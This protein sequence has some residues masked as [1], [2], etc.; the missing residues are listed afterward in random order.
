MR[1]SSLS[2]IPLPLPT[3]YIW[4]S[5]SSRFAVAKLVYCLV[6]KWQLACN[7]IEVVFKVHSFQK[8]YYVSHVNPNVT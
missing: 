3:P 7:F 1:A 8:P 6:L 5:H 4:C 2:P